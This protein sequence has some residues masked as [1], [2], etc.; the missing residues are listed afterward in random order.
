MNNKGGVGK[1][2]TAVVLADCLALDHHKRVLLIDADPQGNSS[3]YFNAAAD[4][5]ADLLAL[6]QGANEPYYPDFVT[7]VRPGVDIIPSDMNLI[8]AEVD[9]ILHPNKCNTNAIEDLRKTIAEDAASPNSE[10]RNTAYD[11]ILIDCP[12]SFSVLTTAS[13]TAADE[14]IIPIA[15]DPFSTAGVANLIVQVQNMQRINDRLRITGLLATR[16]HRPSANESFFASLSEKSHL[17]IYNTK[18]RES[19]LVADALSAGIP[20]TVFSPRCAA[21]IDYRQFV[22]EFLRQEETDNG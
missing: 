17:P 20:L 8:C 14:V 12:P 9:A 6:L 13:L 18:I 16:C 10:D 1:T 4:E 15:I 11:Y 3:Q 7:P 19:P 2:V 22:R 21:S 5:G